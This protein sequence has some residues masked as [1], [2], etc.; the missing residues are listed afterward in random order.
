MPQEQHMFN[1]EDVDVLAHAVSIVPNLE[2]ACF[3][4][5]LA[6]EHLKFSIRSL[7]DMKPL[8][9]VKGLPEDIAKRGIS[10]A[11]V[12]RF[13]PDEFFPIEDERDFLSKV[14]GALAW[15][16][17]VHLH[18]RFLREPKTIVPLRYRMEN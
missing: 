12:K 16:D 10:L 13:L 17:E 14:L 18:E 15:G 3:A 8:F 1:P 5:K 4:A 6:R 9:S 11:H 7:E 2:Y